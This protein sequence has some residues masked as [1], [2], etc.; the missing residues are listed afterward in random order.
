MKEMALAEVR[1]MENLGRQVEEFLAVLTHLRGPTARIDD[2]AVL[3]PYGSEDFDLE[4]AAAAGH[5]HDADLVKLP[6]ERLRCREVMPIRPEQ[7]DDLGHERGE[8]R[9]DQAVGHRRGDGRRG[10]VDALVFAVGGE[11]HLIRLAEDVLVDAA[12]VVVD[13]AAMEDLVPF[14]DAQQQVQ[15]AAEAVQ[16]RGGL[17]ELLPNPLL[18]QLRIVMLIEPFFDALQKGADVGC[19]TFGFPVSLL[20]VIAVLEEAER[21]E[22]VVFQGLGEDEFVDEENNQ[23][24]GALRLEKA[25]RLEFPDPLVEV[26]E[27]HAVKLGLL[28]FILCAAGI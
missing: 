10:V 12:V 17:V 3:Q 15:L 14:R 11:E 4:S 18:K 6:Q 23:F 9:L 25:D 28:Y 27:E 20:A 19:R 8:Q 13:E 16:V 2:P 24:A 22:A 21:D 26:L 7:R 5:I 1:G